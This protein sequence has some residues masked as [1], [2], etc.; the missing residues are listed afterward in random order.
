MASRAIV[1]ACWC[2]AVVVAIAADSN[3]ARAEG[4]PTAVKVGPVLTVADGTATSVASGG[5]IA[6]N[7]VNSEYF[8]VWRNFVPSVELYG[9]GVS[10]DGGFVDDAQIL[11]SGEDPVSAPSIAHDSVH[12]QYLVVWKGLNDRAFGCTVSDAGAPVTEPREVSVAGWEMTAAFNSAV[13]N[14]GEYFLSGRSY[15]AGSPSGIYSERINYTGVGAGPVE[16][17]LR[18]APAPA[19]QIVLNELDSQVLVTWR[20]QVEYNLKGRIIDADGSFATDSFVI[21]SVFPTTV[22]TTGAAFDPIHERYFV[23]FG[24]FQEGPIRGQFVAADGTLDGGPITLIDSVEEEFPGLAYDPVNQVFLLTWYSYW[25]VHC[26]LVSLEGVLLGNP[27]ELS[28]AW[29]SF[30]PSVAASTDRGGFLVVWH[31]TANWSVHGQL[32]GVGGGDLIFS[33]GFEAGNLLLWSNAVP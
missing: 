17:E 12:N 9:R 23:V 29:T 3:I 7:S 20:D 21:S 8:V 13:G 27:V 11:V 25:R 30:R 14:G 1:G 4:E 32:I 10:V 33:N 15:G 22:I 18:G 28:S 5:A 2:V 31:R 24:E 19:G 6:Y 26:Q 16:V